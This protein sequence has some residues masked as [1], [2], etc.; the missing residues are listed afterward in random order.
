MIKPTTAFEISVGAGNSVLDVSKKH[1]HGDCYARCVGIETKALLGC[2]IVFLIRIPASH[3]PEVQKLGSAQ[4]EPTQ[5]RQL[6]YTCI[7]SAVQ[8]PDAV[9][10]EIDAR[11]IDGFASRVECFGSFSTM[12]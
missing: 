7:G 12:C 5:L 2:S 3:S 9:A 10:R 8:K 11:A 4:V 6:G 1:S